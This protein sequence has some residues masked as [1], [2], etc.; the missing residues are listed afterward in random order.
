MVDDK[1]FANYTACIPMPFKFNFSVMIWK[2]LILWVQNVISQTQSN[3]LLLEKLASG[4][5]NSSLANIHL[6]LLFN[7][8]SLWR[9][10]EI[11]EPL[12]DDV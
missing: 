7:S 2:Q 1:R 10:A 9:L 8:G 4:E 12:L 3:L 6:C 11:L 5:F